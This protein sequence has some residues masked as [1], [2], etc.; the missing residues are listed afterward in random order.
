MKWFLALWGIGLALTPG[1]L[2]QDV[3]ERRAACMD[4]CMR[5]RPNPDL[6]REEVLA[7]ERE[8]ARAIQLK[9]PAFFNRLYSEDFSGVS[10]RGEVMTKAGL[11]NSLQ[12]TDVVY[13]TFSASRIKVRIYRDTAVATSLWSMRLT[14]NGQPVSSQMMVT[15]VYVYGPSGYQAISSQTTLLPP[16][17]SLPL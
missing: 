3:Y 8:T 13:Q 7:L 6:Q 12:Q 2:G 4:V 10:S 1:Q 11:L 15:H 17:I 16:Y 5:E 14:V 9:N